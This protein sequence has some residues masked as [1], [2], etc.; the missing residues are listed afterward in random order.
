MRLV[1]IAAHTV[2]RYAVER[3]LASGHELSAI[4][5]LDDEARLAKAGFH[6]FRKEAKEHGI[7][8]YAVG[9]INSPEALSLLQGLHPDLVFVLGWSQL[10]HEEVLAVPSAG[11]VG[12]HTSLLPKNRG[13][14]PLNWALIN[15]D[16]TAGV[17]LF[18]FTPGADTGRLITQ[19]A[20]P[21]ED[22]DDIQTLYDKAELALGAMVE[23][24]LAA[25]PLPEGALQHEEDSS[26]LPRRRPSDGLL[27]FVASGRTVCNTVRA[28]TEPYPCAYFYHQREKVFVLSAATD[29]RTG[30]PGAVLAIADGRMLVAT[31]YGSVWLSRL[32][33]EGL[34]WM[35]ASDFARHVGIRVGQCLNAPSDYDAFVEYRFLDDDG[36]TY[37]KTNVLLGEEGCV[38]VRLVNHT[39][40]PVTV[41]FQL[42]VDGTE[43]ERRTARVDGGR[44]LDT[45]FPFSFSTVGE[46][47]L[48]VVGILPEQTRRDYLVVFARQPRVASTRE[49]RGR[50]KG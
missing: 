18:F 25:D 27:D 17:S 6:S 36:G 19:K 15:G 48:E 35:W 43:R 45:I 31:G 40:N 42:L 30:V 13:R 46:H 20:F 29:E 1:V 24:F 32:R 9:N 37:Y 2:G 44:R 7:P 8:W 12:A 39:D 28:L 16:S 47:R 22:R 33:K 23:E 14:S 10:L 34:P 41:E 50:P 49:E 21:I 26:Y 3:I 11:V 5:T 4:I 38:S